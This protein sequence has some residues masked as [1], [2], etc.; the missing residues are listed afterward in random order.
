[1]LLDSGSKFQCPKGLLY[2][3]PCNELQV[4]RSPGK[5]DMAKCITYHAEPV[6][7]IMARLDMLETEFKE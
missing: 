4:T 6:K 5:P 3:Q 2:E 7:F 1:M